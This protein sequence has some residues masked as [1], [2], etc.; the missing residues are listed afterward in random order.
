MIIYA[1]TIKEF[2]FSRV[3]YKTD[4]VYNFIRSLCKIIPLSML[5]TIIKTVFL[6]IIDVEIIFHKSS[7]KLLKVSVYASVYVYMRFCSKLYWLVNEY[8]IM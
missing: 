2:H 1:R 6:F 7:R 3:E 5:G 4:Q 8:N